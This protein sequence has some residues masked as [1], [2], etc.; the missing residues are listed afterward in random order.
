[1]KGNTQF[2]QLE[3]VLV[4]GFVSLMIGLTLVKFK[5][6]S[7]GKITSLPGTTGLVISN[8]SIP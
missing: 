1:M 6:E 5:I 7:S 3:C 8:V 4:F 2:P